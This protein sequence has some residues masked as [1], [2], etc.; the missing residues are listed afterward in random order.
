MNMLSKIISGKEVEKL[1]IEELRIPSPKQIVNIIEEKK[2]EAQKKEILEKEYQEKLQQQVKQ[3]RQNYFNSL[4]KLAT[5]KQ[6]IYNQLENQL[7]DLVLS[8]CREVIG[9]ETKISPDI[10]LSMLKKGF[11]KIKDDIER[12]PAP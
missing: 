9:T 4:E 2:R 6:T 11:A 5:L 10:L 12:E 1:P 7:M 8:V 3:A